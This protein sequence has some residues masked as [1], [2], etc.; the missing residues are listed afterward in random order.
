MGSGVVSYSAEYDMSSL[1]FQKLD[2]AFSL[3]YLGGKLAVL[4]VSLSVCL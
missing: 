3:T 1:P 2:D 4:F